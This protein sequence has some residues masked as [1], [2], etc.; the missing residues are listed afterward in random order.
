MSKSQFPMP[1]TGGGFLP[2]LVGALLGLAILALVVK[3]PVEAAQ[4]ASGIGGA[5]GAAVE[6]TATF[7]QHVLA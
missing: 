7:L 1:K 6:N 3:Q 5:L 2:K 4:L